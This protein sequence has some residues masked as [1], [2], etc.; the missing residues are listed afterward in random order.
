MSCERPTFCAPE[1]YLYDRSEKERVPFVSE[2]CEFVPAG[3]AKIDGL[4]YPLGYKVMDENLRSL[5]LRKNPN[6]MTFPVD[7][8]VRLPDDEVSPGSADWGGIWSALRKGSIKTL[9][10]YCWEQYGMRTRAFLVA[11]ERPV[12]ANSYRIKSQ[13]VRLLKEIL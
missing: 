11:M 7:E 5:G 10:N 6:I 8:W 9:R 13:G 3:W 4:Y 12:F 1:I 2:E